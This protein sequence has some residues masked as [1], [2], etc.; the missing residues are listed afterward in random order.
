MAE[1]EVYQFRVAFQRISP[2]IWRRLQ[3]LSSQ[4]LADLHFAIQL[5]MG[6]TDEFQHQFVIRNH[7]LGIW[8]PGSFLLFG[9]PRKFS[10][11]QFEFR[12][13][14]RFRY[15]YNFIDEWQLDVRFEGGRPRDS[16]RHYPFCVAG[17]QRAPKESCGG[18]ESF[19][20]RWQRVPTYERAAYVRDTV[21]RLSALIEDTRL[22]ARAFREQALA[23]LKRR[24]P[25]AFDRTE[26]NRWLKHYADGSPW[27]EIC[28]SAFKS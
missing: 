23:T 7:R 1:S 2:K 28:A 13:D 8:R 14:E 3:L 26:V 18:P 22:D 9:N 5:A 17:A 4:S 19:M 16:R 24:A 12:P 25:E 11:Q 21:I 10:L 27:E 15:E 6:W 20:E